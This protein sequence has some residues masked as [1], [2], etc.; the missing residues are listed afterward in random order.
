M[1]KLTLKPALML[2][3]LNNTK[4]AKGEKYDWLR[5]HATTDTDIRWR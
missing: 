5:G 3:S 4:Y 2:I 1:E